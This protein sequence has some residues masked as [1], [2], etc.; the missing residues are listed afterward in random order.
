MNK[1]SVPFWHCVCCFS[2][3]KEAPSCSHEREDAVNRKGKE[4]SISVDG[5]IDECCLHCCRSVHHNA[6]TNCKGIFSASINTAETSRWQ[7]AHRCKTREEAKATSWKWNW[8]K[9]GRLCCRLG[10]HGHSIWQE[11]VLWLYYPRSVTKK[12]PKNHHPASEIQM[13]YRMML[14]IPKT[15][16]PVCTVKFST[17]SPLLSVLSVKYVSSGLARS[18]L[19]WERRN[20]S[21]TI[22]VNKYSFRHSCI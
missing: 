7:D 16:L 8:E 13:L 1:Y 15:P 9:I 19:T 6:E 4:A 18:V 2:A 14:M 11:A 5:R 22:A 17:V 10:C 12:M 3:Q 21:F 20:C